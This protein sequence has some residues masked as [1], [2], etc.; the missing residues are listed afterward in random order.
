MARK[1]IAILVAVSMLAAF[2]LLSAQEEKAKEEKPS[3]E[4]V[5]AKK[6]RICH[7]KDGI[8]ESW[9]ATKHATA[10]ES[11]GEENQKKEECIGCHSTG[12][13]AKGDLLT[14]VQCEACH[15]PG[16]E[17]KSK[18]IMEDREKAI[19]NGLLIPDEN[20]CKNCHNENVPE[21]FRPEKPY[22]F[23]EMMKTGLHDMPYSAEKEAEKKGEKEEGK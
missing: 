16:S 18:S 2:S 17:Y 23:A 11:L 9:M 15:G 21:E 4:Y 7:K 19:A 10:W 8:H 20:T 13:T 14:G 3:Y 6:C 22:D 5:G 12:T 1:L